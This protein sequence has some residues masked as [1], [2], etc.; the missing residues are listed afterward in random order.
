MVLRMFQHLFAQKANVATLPM[1]QR[2]LEKDDRPI[3]AIGDLH[4]CAG[5]LRRIETAISQ[6]MNGKAAHVVL[7]GDV[8]DRGPDS[9]EMLDHLL[10]RPPLGQ[11]RHVL[12]GNHEAMFLRFLDCPWQRLG[13]LDHGGIETLQSYGIDGHNF[14][15]WPQRKQRLQVDSHIPLQHKKFLTNLPAVLTWGTVVF[16]HAG[17]DFTADFDTQSED[18]V[19]WNRAPLAPESVPEGHIFVHG[20]FPIQTPDLQNRVINVDVGA[21]LKNRASILRIDPDE[22]M[23]LIQV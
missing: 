20:H 13:W 10:R 9:A 5:L 17:L 21:Y 1:V 19:L 8:I 2:S 4:G 15:S 22:K 3:Y 16:A 18:Q 23:A 6:D 14:A 12:L 11:T 7:L